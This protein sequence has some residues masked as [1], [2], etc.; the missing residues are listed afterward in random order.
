MNS[1]CNWARKSAS[2][3]EDGGMEGRDVEGAVEVEGATSWAAEVVAVDLEV[4][5]L[6]WSSM[7]VADGQDV[8]AMSEF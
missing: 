3:S 2:D 7:S 4:D 5:G 1:D 6:N 8:H